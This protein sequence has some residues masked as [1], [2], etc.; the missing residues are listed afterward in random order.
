MTDSGAWTAAAAPSTA[1]EQLAREL[2]LPE[3]IAR[4]LITRGYADADAAKTFLDP[5]LS[6]LHDPYAM[7]GMREAVD[8]IRQALLAYEPILIYGDYDVDGTVATVLLK[9]ACER[10]A[11]ALGVTPDIRYHIPHRIREGYGMRESRIADAAAEGVRLVVSVDTGIRA[12]AAAEEAARLGLDLIVTDHHLPDELNGTPRALAV[13]NPNQPGCEYPCKNLCGA[14]VAFKLAQALLQGA[15][16]DDAEHDRLRSK[17]LPSFLKLLAVATIADSVP[18]T[19]ENRTIASIGLRELRSPAQPGL[20][21]LMELAGIDTSRSVSATDVGF[22]LAPR[23]NAAGRM[24]IASDVVELFLTRDP[25]VAR[26]LAEKLHRL[27][28]DRRASEA[29]ALREIEQ[30]IEALLAAPGG[31]PACLVLDDNGTQTA[32]WH[33]GVVGILAS[34]VVE[35]TGRPALVLAHEKTTDPYEIPLAHGSG[36]SVPGFHLLDALTSAHEQ[37]ASTLFSRFGGH[38]H[39]VGFALPSAHVP[40]LRDSLATMAAS[41]LG[42]TPAAEELRFDLELRF[43]EITPD[44]LATL[45]QLAPFGL[46]NPDPI[47]VTRRARL[48]TP[49][50]ILADR[51]VRL[52]L[53]DHDGSGRFSGVVW[54]RRT[55]WAEQ[56]RQQ[57]W[58]PG[59]SFDLAYHLRRNWHPDFGG[60]ELEIIALERLS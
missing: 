21:A 5:S 11:A 46:G 54:S 58:M 31:L 33:R 19:D 7:H 42:L 60:W 23:L 44:L 48:L 15:A 36:R 37:S 32:G 30:Q 39:A 57:S 59:D 56:S 34:R 52:S 18:L 13:L 45:E 27:N 12:H 47:F 51:H 4:L 38:A 53:E 49:P 2:H 14:A 22:R 10:T 28:D 17:T 16:R 25:A 55:S 1:S 6:H 20:R 40:Q 29:N 43:A 3:P 26:T 9:T 50:R 41:Q 24:E 8:R 35:R